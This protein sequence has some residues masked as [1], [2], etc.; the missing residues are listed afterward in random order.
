MRNDKNKQIMDKK[1]T[2]YKGFDK[3]MQCMGFQYE[4]GKEYEIDGGIKCCSRGFHACESPLEVF[5]HYDMLNSRFC[6]VELSGEIDRDARTTK[7]CSS[8]IKI[9]K[10][11]KLSDI[12]KIGVE[13]LND[14]AKNRT[15]GA[16]N[17][18]GNYAQIGSCGYNAQ[19]GSCGNDAVI[20]CSGRNSKARQKSARG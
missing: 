7:I 15:T 13:W 4:A 19:I 10:E 9:K 11:L 18:S 8:K 5:D 3:K 20:M 6:E 14:V 16:L 12:I 1:I 2:A 17:D